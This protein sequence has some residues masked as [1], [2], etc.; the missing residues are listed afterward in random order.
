MKQQQLEGDWKEVRVTFP[1]CRH[2]KE[3]NRTHEKLVPL[4]L[5]FR[6]GVIATATSVIPEQTPSW[7]LLDTHLET[8]P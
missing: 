5:K 3:A 6:E 4:S 1:W 7:N 8:T 2:Q